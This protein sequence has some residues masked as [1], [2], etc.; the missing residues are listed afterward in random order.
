MDFDLEAGFEVEVDSQSPACTATKPDSDATTSTTHD[1]TAVDFEVEV[2]GNLPH[3][4]QPPVDRFRSMFGAYEP[5]EIL[6]RWTD[7][8]SS[9]RDAMIE[10]VQN[11]AQKDWEDTFVKPVPNGGIPSDLRSHCIHLLT[12][13]YCTDKS[14]PNLSKQ[15]MNL[16]RRE[17]SEF[18]TVPVS[19]SV[20]QDANDVV[21]NVWSSLA[22]G[23]FD[24]C[25]RDHW[26]KDYKRVAQAMGLLQKSCLDQ[27][28]LY[29]DH[30]KQTAVLFQLRF[31]D[32]V[33]EAASKSLCATAT[34]LLRDF[35]PRD[36]C[37]VVYTC[38]T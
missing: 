28:H 11:T 19:D 33:S 26:P 17:M 4:T 13:R 18:T 8:Q 29:V 24:E 7:I 16:V 6:Y 30:V 20:A 23:E 3:G 38:E 21:G 32:K 14:F 12:V 2:E 31:N 37:S 15:Y 25:K 27:R 9:H 10:W 36:F 5:W 35:V 34:M 22:K 1:A